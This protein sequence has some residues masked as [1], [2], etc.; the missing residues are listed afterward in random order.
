[1]IQSIIVTE[2]IDFGVKD[3]AGVIGLLN[4]KTVKCG[5]MNQTDD[6]MATIDDWKMLKAGF[7]EAIKRE[8]A[9]NFVVVDVSDSG[10]WKHDFGNFD[11]GKVHDGRDNMAFAAVEN[12][13]RSTLQDV[14]KLFDSFWSIR[15]SFGGMLHA[16]W[17]MIF[18]LSFHLCNFGGFGWSVI[19][20]GGSKFPSGRNTIFFEPGVDPFGETCE[21]SY[22]GFVENAAKSAPKLEPSGLRGREET[23]GC[24]FLTL[25]GIII[26]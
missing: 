23:S 3:F 19:L 6:T 5:G 11:A 16:R 24:I 10:R 21:K 9:K 13:T 4:F 14:E 1:M 18:G 12:G 8:R 2:I 25:H 20:G 7:V 15:L 17:S 22:L 26:A